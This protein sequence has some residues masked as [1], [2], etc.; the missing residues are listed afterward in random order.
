MTNPSSTDL[1]TQKMSDRPIFI[2]GSPRSGTTLMRSIVDAH[3]NICCPPWE[4]GLLVH[5]DRVVNGDVKALL[6]KDKSFPVGRAD[7]IAWARRSTEDL[8]ALF[9][10][11]TGKP[12]WAEKTPAHVFHI[13][14]IHEVFPRAQF[15][16]MIRNGRDVVRS[17]QNMAFAPRAIRW[18][19]R[20]W[21]DSVKA[22]RAL[23]QKLP[24]DQYCEVRYEDLIREPRPLVERLCGFLGEPFAPQMLEFHKPE[25]NSWGKQDKPLQ[26]K[27]VNKYRELGFVERAIFSWVASPLLKELNYH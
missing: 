14:L 27:P 8:I 9:A 10:A 18:S 16:H 15:V 5:L 6:E 20:R 12:R 21:V 11:K 4:T 3:P 26:D 19:S 13:D 23:G 7:L 25:N 17:L 2:V 1:S 24:A 22:G